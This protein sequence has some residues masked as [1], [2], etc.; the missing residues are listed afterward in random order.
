MRVVQIREEPVKIVMW[1]GRCT[2]IEKQKRAEQQLKESRESLRVLAET[3]PQLVWVVGPDGL[4]EYVN[5]RCCD[6]LGLTAEHMQ[7]NPWPHLQ[8]IPPDH[9]PTNQPL[10]PHP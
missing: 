9:R 2:D 3:V 10:R 8:F 4:H 5:Q 1:I 7:S 6:Y